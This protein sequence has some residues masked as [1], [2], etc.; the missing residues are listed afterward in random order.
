METISTIKIQI[1]KLETQLKTAESTL[2]ALVLRA[3]DALQPHVKK[4]MEDMVL[5]KLKMT[6][7]PTSAAGEA[8]IKLVKTDLENLVSQLP[9]I[10]REVIGNSDDWPHQKFK[11]YE[12]GVESFRTAFNAATWR[13]GP[14]LKNHGLIFAGDTWE[15]TENTSMHGY[16]TYPGKTDF[17]PQGVPEISSYLTVFTKFL[18]DKVE[19]EEKRDS[20]K[21]AMVQGIW[22]K[23]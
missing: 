12:M 11:G 18:A 14:L 1:G 17:Q 10:C 22:D 19:L 4:W 2:D 9:I 3:A 21:Q 5:Q 15:V 16:K 20:L 6:A 13:L 8:R 7:D 23:E